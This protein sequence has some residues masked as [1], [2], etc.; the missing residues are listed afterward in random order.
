[1]VFAANLPALPQLASRLRRLPRTNVRTL[2]AV[3]LALPAVAVAFTVN[4]LEMPKGYSIAVYAADVPNA[5][6]MAITPSGVVFV[7]S[8]HLGKVYALLDNDHDNIADETLV[9]AR[10]LN[11]P[12]GVAFRGGALYVA[13]VDRISRFDNIERRLSDPGQPVVVSR[14]LPNERHHGW[15]F[16]A[17]G[18]DGRLYVPVGAPCNVCEIDPPFGT[19]LSMRAD[20]GGQLTYARG[21]RNTVGFDWDPRTGELWFADN[22]RDHLGDDRPPCELNHAPRAGLHFGFP[23]IHG[24]DVPDRRYGVGHDA[25]EFTSTLR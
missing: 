2:L 9:V 3:L 10:G 17:F 14:E 11:M 12:S 21:I 13:E 7:G 23:Y 16:I 19:I 1:M 5:R 15:K 8:L 20:G 6:Q 22:G 4:D 24:D 25:S 18:P